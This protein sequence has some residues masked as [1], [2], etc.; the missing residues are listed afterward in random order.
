MRLLS[1]LTF[2]A[3]TSALAQ[4]TSYQCM[5]RVGTVLGVDYW[6]S[7]ASQADAGTAVQRVPEFLESAGF[8]NRWAAFLNSRFNAQPGLTAED[9]VMTAVVRYVLDNHKPWRDVYVGRFVMSGPGGYPKISEDPTKPPHGFFGL[10][11]WQRRYAGNDTEGL[12]LQA[13]YRIMRAT[14]GLE[15]VPSPQNASGDATVTGRARPECRSCHFTSPYA[16]DHVAGLL[17]WY[18]KGIGSRLTLEPRAPTPAPLFD[19]RQVQS[20]DELL[21]LAVDSDA[22]SFWTC[23]LAFEFAVGRPET[24][25]EA[26]VFDACVDALRRTGDVRAGLAAIMQDPSYCADL[27]P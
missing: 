6:W 9:D 26:P 22:F 2:L 21:A 11:A 15:L 25:C 18:R 10:S 16:L 3:A 24:G 4:E 12:P 20:L 7:K 5:R 27:W 19:G 13:A 1:L 14:I 8:G 23:R 17:P